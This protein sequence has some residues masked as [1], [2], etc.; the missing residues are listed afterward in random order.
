M[1][2][3]CPWRCYRK[4]RRCYWELWYGSG[5]W[6]T[7]HYQ[8]RD[9]LETKPRRQE[10]PHPPPRFGD[11]CQDATWTAFGMRKERVAPIC[12]LKT[13]LTAFDIFDFFKRTRNSTTLG[14][15]QLL[16][17][18]SS[19]LFIAQ[20]LNCRGFA[21]L[22]E[23]TKIEDS[24]LVF[25][26]NAMWKVFVRR[27]PKPGI[28]QNIST[29]T[30]HCCI[31]RPIHIWVL[32]DTLDTRIARRHAAFDLFN[33]NNCQTLSTTIRPTDMFVH[34]SVD[35]WKLCPHKPMKTALYI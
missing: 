28:S 21:S 25:E 29:W 32:P 24:L 31:S 6:I 33:A 30:C 16:P 3:T 1:I 19:L 5:S 15:L 8:A 34:I 11:S 12:F 27:W 17:S 2:N 18:R 10:P 13:K 4:E 35:Q 22:Q 14:L 20:G 26:Q 23:D 7:C 9:G